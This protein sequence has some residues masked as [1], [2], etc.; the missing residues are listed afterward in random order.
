[1]VIGFIGAELQNFAYPS[2]SC[3]V[4]NAAYSTILH[5][6]DNI[7]HA[8]TRARAHTHTRLMALFP[9]LPKWAGTRKV[10]P[11]WIL[12]KQETVRASGISW[13]ICK[14]ASH[15]RQITTPAPHSFL[16]AGCPD[17][18]SVKAM[19]AY[20]NIRQMNTNY[21]KHTGLVASGLIGFADTF[22]LAVLNELCWLDFQNTPPCIC[23]QQ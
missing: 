8:R 19:K 9:G 17:G 3:M 1:M 23:L 21:N 4:S 10:K 7:T 13:A 11:I 12:L 18:H 14:S 16:Q 5:M 6:H 15:S 22:L 2:D 20:D